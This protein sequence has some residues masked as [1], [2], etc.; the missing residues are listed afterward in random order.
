MH[1]KTRLYAGVTAIAVVILG[2]I[3]S[4]ITVERVNNGNVGLKVGPS[5]KIVSDKPVSPGFHFAGFGRIIV[6]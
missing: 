6:Q 2:G 5:G 4:F 3:F 1:H